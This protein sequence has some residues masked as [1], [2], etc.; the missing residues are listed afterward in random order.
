MRINFDTQTGLRNNLGLKGDVN[1][2]F[3][4]QSGIVNEDLIKGKEVT[5]IGVG[6]IGSF[7]ALALTKLGVEHMTVYDEDGVSNHNIP[8][9][10]YRM[11]DVNKFKGEAMAEII[12]EFNGVTIQPK[13]EFYKDQPLSEVVIVATDSMTSRKMV[14]KQFVNQDSAKVLIEARMGGELGYVYLVVKGNDKHMTCYEE[15]LYSDEEAAD[16]PCTERSIIY[17]V[18]MIASLI[19]RAFKAV[20]KGEA[21]YPHEYVFDM[22]HMLT[23]D[24][25]E[26]EAMEG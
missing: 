21:G 3:T 11:K 23:Y 13:L 17:N 22:N 2:D 18:L 7:T 16:I 8:N 10:F 6:S 1:M 4:R 26:V 12:Q 14:W 5:L 25:R 15:N 9:Q 20:V 24:Q 19:C